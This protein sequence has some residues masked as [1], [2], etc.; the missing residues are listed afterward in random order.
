[1]DDIFTD[2]ISNKSSSMKCSVIHLNYYCIHCIYIWVGVKL[3]SMFCRRVILSIEYGRF[4]KVYK[5]WGI[6]LSILYTLI[7]Q[8][9]IE[10]Y[11][12]DY[13]PRAVKVLIV[14]IKMMYNKCKLVIFAI[15]SILMLCLCLHWFGNW[16]LPNILQYGYIITSKHG[17][18]HKNDITNG[19]N[20]SRSI[21]QV[22]SI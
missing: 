8:I 12:V 7:E 10:Y 18:T 2:H 3:S 21:P 19:S 17:S 20:I 4:I 6:Q 14:T 5:I 13:V 16:W 15:F 1:M 9:Y 22:C 11:E